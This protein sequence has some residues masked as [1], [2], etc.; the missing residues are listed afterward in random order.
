MKIEKLSDD[1]QLGLATIVDFIKGPQRTLV[2]KGIAGTGKSTLIQMIASYF[3]GDKYFCFTAPTNK[4]TKV[5]RDMSREQQAGV[6]SI[7]TIHSLL[8]LV[9]TPE[10]AIKTLKTRGER[11]EVAYADV[12]VIDEGSM[13]GL[14][15]SQRIEAVLN[16]YPQ[17]KVIY[18][19]D[20]MQLPPIGEESSPVFHTSQ[21]IVEL[22]EI[23][24]QAKDNPIIQLCS[25]IRDSIVSGKRSFNLETVKTPEGN[26]IFCLP[27]KMFIDWSRK[28]YSSDAY[29]DDPNSF[30]TIAWR[31][32]TV[33]DSNDLIRRALYPA[34]ADGSMEAF[35]P[36]ER[37]VV[38]APVSDQ[39]GNEIL[40]HTDSEGIVKD[41]QLLP[42]HPWV[43]AHGEFKV[44][45]LMVDF[46]G[47]GK[48][49]CFALHPDSERDYKKTLS[50]LSKQAHKT[51]SMWGSFWAFK[52]SFHDVR[53]A[54]AVTSH[55][56]QGSTYET[57]FVKPGDILLNRNRVESFKSLY[58]SCS[59]ASKNLI[60]LN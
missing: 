52:E 4:A 7:C 25:D 23:V 60:I 11:D 6:S 9:L 30:K 1:Q 16:T 33:D 32:V 21:V 38:A 56:S 49:P 18:M 53:Y 51:S 24:R 28:A 34:N 15:M 19:G 57:V 26:G 3:H 2:L 42:V 17:L 36:D 59:R 39:W 35:M 47:L 5:L 29:K 40:A 10:G 54:H 13:I 41:K 8:G 55:R 27:R 58:V 44:Y 31:N 22:I 45:K 48:V 20:P 37:V 14:E 46:Y 12:I 43:K 50:K